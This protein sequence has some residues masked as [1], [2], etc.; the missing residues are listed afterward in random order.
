VARKA[1]HYPGFDTLLAV[2]KEVVRLTN[3]PHQYTPADGEKLKELLAEVEARANNEKFEDAV[4]EKAVLLVFKIASGQH[5][6][7]GNKR[8]A[9]V[10]GLVF[11]RKNGFSIEIDSE[12]FA[13]TVDKV[14]I[15][16]SNFDDLYEVMKGLISKSKSD[17]KSWEKVIAEEVQ[18]RSKFLTDTSS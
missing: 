13:S 3:E 16:A 6:R 4:A 2:N 14:G 10:A 7:S 11:L 12:A 9:M 15:A 17:R 18:Q 5:F 8:T 1:V